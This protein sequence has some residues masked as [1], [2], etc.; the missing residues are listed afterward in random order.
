MF[1]WP[2]I[3]GGAPRAF[4][5]RGHL[6]P[7]FAP[8]TLGA[9]AALCERRARGRLNRVREMKAWA[10]AAVFLLAACSNT[11]GTEDSTDR[12]PASGDA[13]DRPSARPTE[14]DDGTDA[15]SHPTSNDSEP[16]PESEP[17]PVPGAPR[18]GGIAP[19]DS[20]GP[21]PAPA[22]PDQSQEPG[23]ASSPVSPTE[24]DA[25][26]ADSLG[27]HPFVDSA[28]TSGGTMTFRNVGAQGWWPRRID[29]E[30][31]DPACDYKDGEDT[32][33]G[34]CCMTQHETNSTSLSPFD[35]EMTLIVKAV[36]VKQLAVYQPADQS[37]SAWRR[38][39]SFDERTG[40][41]DNLW[42]TRD[43]AG[44]A[45][46]P[47]DLTRD[48]CVG[49]VSQV[50]SVECG[51]GSDYFCPNDPGM[52]HRGYRGSK[53]VV[54]LGSMDFDDADV[55][56]CNGDGD[57][58]P[59]PWV[60]FV[61]SELIRD[62]GRKWN[63]LCN[64]YSKT[65]TVGDGCGEI[66]VFEVVM[67]GNEYSNREFISTGVRSYQEGHV[68]GAV[69]GAD[70]MR[71]DFPDDV[72][73]VNACAKSAYDMGPVIEVGGDTDGCPVWRR[74]NGDR[75]FFILLDEVTRSIQVGIL[76][77]SNLPGTVRGLLPV[78]PE[79]VDRATIDAFADL[80][81]H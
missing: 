79:S 41:S 66:N 10:T 3:D 26:R 12:E 71:D 69:C 51:D 4:A 36:H 28:I 9:R 70:C 18:P 14:A 61:A 37:A 58:N 40:E 25:G 6:V 19:V 44:A 68:G 72:D 75:Y 54:F 48:D 57:G 33:G 63:G 56:S 55:R 45:S 35:E 5:G 47:G 53:L 42:F 11:G 8:Y 80:R 49:Y 67:D 24:A 27:A 52:L 22:Q 60:A 38:V 78:L 81:L 31:G 30:P 46:F 13:G 39:T 7:P 29:R 1:N 65:G 64:C 73:V 15:P 32:W 62:G 77:P 59:A 2:A 34:H 21:R 43:G 16:P 76:H 50:A 17:T 20:E 74:P 23:Q